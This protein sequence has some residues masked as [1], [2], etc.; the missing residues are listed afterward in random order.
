MLLSPVEDLMNA[1]D[2]DGWATIP[3]WVNPTDS[4][5][6]KTECE[7]SWEKGDFRR[8]GVGRGQGLEIR[9]EIRRDQVMWLDPGGFSAE[10]S[11]YLATLERVRKMLDQI[12]ASGLLLQIVLSGRSGLHNNFKNLALC[13]FQEAEEK[14]FTLESL[15]KQST[16]DYLNHAMQHEGQ[17]DKLHAFPHESAEKI[18][19][20]SGGNFRRCA[21]VPSTKARPKPTT[22]IP[23]SGD[24]SCM[25]PL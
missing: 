4:N 2:R 22:R 5:R 8:A 7:A 12:Y 14:H 15:S 17:M 9:E 24:I 3:G 18:F 19:A 13:N 25:S 21:A 6:L 11:I 23:I 1:M 20:G 10:Q 16:F